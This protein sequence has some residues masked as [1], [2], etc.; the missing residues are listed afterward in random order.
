MTRPE[1]ITFGWVNGNP[2]HPSHSSENQLGLTLANDSAVH[3]PTSTRNLVPAAVGRR[4]ALRYLDQLW[5]AGADAQGGG[6]GCLDPTGFVTSFSSHHFFRRSPHISFVPNSAFLLLP[7][8]GHDHVES[9]L[10]IPSRIQ[11]GDEYRHCL[12]Y[13]SSRIRRPPRVPFGR[14]KSAPVISI[15]ANKATAIYDMFQGLPPSTIEGP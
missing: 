15:T 5:D 13:L 8:H 2:S 7:L 14:Q 1:N 3:R 10:T 4:G 6:I 12:S 11:Q 9:L